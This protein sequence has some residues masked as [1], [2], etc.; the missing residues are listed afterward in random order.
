MS[1]AG[2]FGS[3]QARG[4]KGDDSRSSAHSCSC[5]GARD[6]RAAGCCWCAR[7]SH[8]VPP[9]CTRC[10]GSRGSKGADQWSAG[11]RSQTCRQSSWRGSRAAPRQVAA[12]SWS[13]RPTDPAGIRT[14]ARGLRAWSAAKKHTGEGR[15]G[16]RDP[17]VRRP[18]AGRDQLS[19]R[20]SL[21]RENLI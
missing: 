3:R 9:K 11:R 4:E 8:G 14:S 20:S 21:D 15:G 17:G 6:Q 19:A 16:R 5:Q 1:S 12:W 2:Q 7:G 13:L 10:E 18:G